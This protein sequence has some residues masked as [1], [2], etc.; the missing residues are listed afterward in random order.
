MLTPEAE[1]KIKQ[2]LICKEQLQDKRLSIE[3]KEARLFDIERLKSAL[4]EFQISLKKQ[5]FEAYEDSTIIEE[6]KQYKFISYE[7]QKKYAYDSDIG[8]LTNPR[9]EISSVISF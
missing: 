5:D 4:K 3:E 7:N 2:L 8:F 9:T 6:E 1:K